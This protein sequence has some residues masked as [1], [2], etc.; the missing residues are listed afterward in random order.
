M[1]HVATAAGAGLS[2]SLACIGAHSLQCIAHALLLIAVG[3]SQTAAFDWRPGK[4]PG[5]PDLGEPGMNGTQCNTCHTNGGGTARNPFGLAWEATYPRSE[6]FGLAPEVAFAPVA[7]LDSD[8]DG[9]TN[10]QE[11][12]AGTHPGNA[13]SQPA[14]Q[15]S[16]PV[17]EDV[18]VVAVEDTTAT[19]ALVASDAD[20]DP[21]TFSIVAAPQNGTAEINGADAI[22]TPSPDFNGADSFAYSV[23]DGVS[24]SAAAVTITIAPVNDAPL[25][26]VL[27]QTISED[28]TARFVLVGSDG[29]GDALS[30]GISTTP[31]SGEVTLSDDTVQ[32][33]PSQDFNGI[34][35]F[36]YLV[37]DGTVDSHAAEVVITVLA[38]NDAPVATTIF[39]TTA[40]DSPTTLS[41]SVVDVDGDPL[42]FV[43]VAAPANGEV[44]LDDDAATYTPNSD[45]HGSDSFSFTATD[46][47]LTSTAAFAMIVVTPVND[48]PSADPAHVVVQSADVSAT[49]LLTGRD[50]DGDA[51]TYVVVDLPTHGTLSGEPPG[52]TYTP[53]AGYAGPD[54][55]TYRVLDSESE[56]I[57]ASVTIDVTAG[58]RGP[59]ALPQHIETDE[60]NAVSIVLTA[61]DPSG[62]PL[63]FSLLVEPTHGTLEGD[64]PTL[65]YVPELDFHG[66]DELT[67]S[68]N[69]G[70]RHSAAA[71][72]TIDVLPINDAPIADDQ[73]IE[74]TEDSALHVV[75]VGSDVDGDALTYE[76]VDLPGHGAVAGIP[77]NVTY[78]PDLNYHGRDELSYTVSDGLLSTSEVVVT[79]T[80]DP[81]DDAPR[82]AQEGTPEA[83]RVS[84]GAPDQVIGLGNLYTDP[85]SPVTLSAESSD[86][87]VANARISGMDL[88][89][90]CDYSAPGL[91]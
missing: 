4:L 57:P 89:L 39:A 34:D 62:G 75:L 50:P 79:L 8:G 31:T 35:Q 91:R 70:M 42:T 71:S 74:M 60:D 30:Y 25:A 47:V 73:H 49:V 17:A 81:V 78:T 51:L 58:A 11:L 36:T 66:A 13:A 18:T 29:D 43:I 52:L 77:P 46:G 82:L 38:V 83:I 5:I 2:L 48:T 20:G 33:T 12:D 19:I 68:V 86:L 1:T 23:S 7:N 53:E 37:N 21:L 32:Y 64:A 65:I 44:I 3:V 61:A 87:A 63:T 55:F 45:F 54:I 56:S 80:V 9:H 90:S 27:S 26:L 15:N 69:D 59:I 22:Y 76:L 40:E 84:R 67:F 88:Y 24:G 28:T 6:D 72:I 14:P 41:L 10:V 85:D 16:P